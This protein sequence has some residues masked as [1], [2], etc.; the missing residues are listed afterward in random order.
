MNRIGKSKI[1]I[2]QLT[3]IINDGKKSAQCI[4]HGVTTKVDVEHTKSGKLITSFEGG[5]YE[6]MENIALLVG[7]DWDNGRE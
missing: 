3:F 7:Q 4:E 2:N 6:C 5:F 1:E